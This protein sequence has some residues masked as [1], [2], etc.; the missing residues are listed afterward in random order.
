MSDSEEVKGA[1]PPTLQTMKPFQAIACMATLGACII[2]TMAYKAK[3]DTAA[4]EQQ[5][6][7]ERAMQSQRAADKTREQLMESYSRVY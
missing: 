6:Q 7:H 1:T 2:G 5:Y 4:A 3:L